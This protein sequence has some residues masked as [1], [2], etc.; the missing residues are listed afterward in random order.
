[1]SRNGFI[2]LWDAFSLRGIICSEG[3]GM[4]GF[5]AVKIRIVQQYQC[6]HWATH[7]LSSFYTGQ[8]RLQQLSGVLILLPILSFGVLMIPKATNTDG[9]QLM[10][11]LARHVIWIKMESQHRV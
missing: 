5:G 7:V 9:T 6:C 4:K 2:S 11:G 1:M 8:A 3:K 10:I